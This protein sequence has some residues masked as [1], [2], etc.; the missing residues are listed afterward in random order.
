MHTGKCGCGAVTYEMTADPMFV[1]NCHCTDCQRQ[2]GS[3]Y[4]LNA[5]IEADHLNVSGEVTHHVVSTPSGGGQRITRCAQCGVAIFSLYLIRGE[6][7]RFLRVGTL[8]DPSKCPPYVQIFTSSKQPWVPLSDK[9]PAFEE[10]Y[11]M[12][13]V[14]PEDAFARRAACLA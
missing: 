4:V 12:K 6:K 7:L 14:W 1:H 8:D 3:A 9:I 2:T 11:N 13:E 5:I 10:Y